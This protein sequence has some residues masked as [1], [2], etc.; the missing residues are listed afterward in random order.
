MVEAA[1]IAAR[2]QGMGRFYAL[3]LC[4]GG[5]VRL[6][7]A[8]DGNRLLAEA[9]FPWKFGETYLLTLQVEGSRI[10]AFVDNQPIFDAL[11][12]HDPLSSG[13]IA[14]VCEAGRMG[15]Q[16]VVVGPLE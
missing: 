4:K 13:G 1:G 6:V 7:K 3:L 14:L 5:K 8:L 15:V 10:R 11:D 16:Q 12:P 9:E 2:V